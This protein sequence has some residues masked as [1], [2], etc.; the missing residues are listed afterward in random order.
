[1]DNNQTAKSI[2]EAIAI[3]RRQ[4][5]RPD[6]LSIAKL[7]ASKHGLSESMVIGTVANLLSE[8]VIYHKPNKQGDESFYISK[9]NAEALSIIETDEE[10]DEEEGIDKTRPQ[11]T[12]KNGK[13][14]IRF[15]QTTSV[16]WKTRL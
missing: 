13:N 4:R 14:K 7:V 1:M 12:Q 8:A 10:E 15:L 16:R 11:Q 3:L 5:K 6:R 2:I 9:M